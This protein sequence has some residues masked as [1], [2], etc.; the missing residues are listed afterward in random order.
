LPEQETQLSDE[1]MPE[2]AMYWTNAPDFIVAGT[3]AGSGT[4]T[5]AVPTHADM[6]IMLGTLHAS[7]EDMI[8]A[9][10]T[11]V[12]QYEKTKALFL[13]DKDW[14]YGQQA[15]ME[16]PVM[17]PPTT[18]NQTFSWQDGILPDPIQQQATEF[19]NGSGSDLGINAIQ[20]EVLRSVADS[21]AL[22]G[23]FIV[24]INNAGAA[25]AGADAASFFPSGDTNQ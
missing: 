4:P 16:G 20:T 23:Q 2:L 14:V 13:A 7:E 11:V 22:L 1:V 8:E 9:S 18:P 5:S 3:P 25:Y 19:A 17:G 10:T 24:C 21:M 6:D 15:E 12:N